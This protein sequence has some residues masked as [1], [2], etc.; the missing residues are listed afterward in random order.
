METSL[1]TDE[2]W[3]ETQHNTTA[4]SVK[5]FNSLLYI[6]L[7]VYD[8]GVTLFS[9]SFSRFCTDKWIIWT[10]RRPFSHVVQKLLTLAESPRILRNNVD[11]SAVFSVMFCRSLLVILS[12]FFCPL[13]CLSIFDLQV[14]IV[15]LVSST[16]FLSTWWKRDLEVYCFLI[17]WLFV[18]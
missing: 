1:S 6:E 14:C 5:L 18:F 11:Q 3:L 17:V 4:K 2:R 15:P 7:S 16:F 9:L 12:F 8:L 13:F 10:V